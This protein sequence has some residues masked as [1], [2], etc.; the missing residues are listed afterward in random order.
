MSGDPNPDFKGSYKLERQS[1]NGD[2]GSHGRLK[3]RQC[4]DT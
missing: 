4:S 3:I 1:G 2:Q